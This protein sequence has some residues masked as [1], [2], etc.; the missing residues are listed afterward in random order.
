MLRS[1]AGWYRQL[2][3][4]LA[5]HAVVDQGIG[6]LTVLGRTEPCQGFTVLREISQ[7]TTVKLSAG[8]GTVPQARPGGA[9]RPPAGGT[10]RGLARHG[11]GPLPAPVG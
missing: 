6:V 2:K 1:G 10:A 3:Q 8:R 7:H 4:A 5:S 9:A 11:A